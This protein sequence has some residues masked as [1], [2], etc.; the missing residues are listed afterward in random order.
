PA[1]PTTSSA[2]LQPWAEFQD[3]SALRPPASLS[4]SVCR[5][6]QNL[7][8]FRRNY[9]VLTIIIFLLTLLTRP[10]SLLFFLCLSAA[11]IYFVL[12]RDYPLHDHRFAIGFLGVVT[13][14]ALFW[15]HFWTKLFLSSMIGA[16]LALVHGVSRLPEDYSIGN[17]SGG[18]RYATF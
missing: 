9:V 1:E 18:Y 4:E 6:T 17:P 16:A 10:H 3:L 7:R 12:S 5:V 8:Y 2:M 15:N 14:S 13:L 11:W